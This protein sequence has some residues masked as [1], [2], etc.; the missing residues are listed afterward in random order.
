LRPALSRPQQLSYPHINGLYLLLRAS[1]LG[2]SS[3]QGSSGRLAVSE[4]RLEQWNALNP[5][6]RYFTLMHAMLTGDWGPIDAGS[7]RRGP[8]DDMVWAFR[9]Q[10]TQRIGSA[11]VGAPAATHFYSWTLQTTAALLELFG[12]LEIPRVAPHG[13]ESWRITAV[14]RT[15]FGQALM[16]RLLD[17][18]EDDYFEV[19]RMSRG[20][21]DGKFKWLGE[22]FSDCFPD[23]RNT[24]PEAEDEFVEGIWQFQV[25]LGQVWRRIVI[26]ADSDV[27]EL[28]ATILIAFKFDDDHLYDVKLRD[29]SGRMIE[30]AHPACD[31]ADWFTDEFAIGFLPL[32]PGQSMTLLYDYGDSW[33]FTIK[34]EKILPGDARIRKPKITAKQGKAPQQY[35]NSDD[36]W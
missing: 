2:V 15:D 4:K 17:P 5:Q 19:C 25:S 36:C 18:M 23:C 26:P 33:Q 21:T 1:G 32:D 13:G 29:R 34:L 3:G 8:W 28:I 35:A 20:R 14:R 7:S 27:D 11:K 16:D 9:G 30:I 6:E 10:R 31:D 12:I 22:L 24:L